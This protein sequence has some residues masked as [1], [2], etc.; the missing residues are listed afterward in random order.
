MSGG[1][2]GAGVSGGGRGQVWYTSFIEAHRMP[3]CG[4]PCALCR[5]F[6]GGLN[7]RTE[8]YLKEHDHL[9]K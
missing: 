7:R 1:G 6:N 9:R 3:L 8:L 5:S 2:E 4:G